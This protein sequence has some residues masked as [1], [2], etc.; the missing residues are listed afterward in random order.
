MA[1]GKLRD[2]RA[3]QVVEAAG[4]GRKAGAEATGKLT[5]QTGITPFKGGK[6]FVDK[7]TGETV[8]LTESGEVVPV[9]QLE[10]P[11]T[12]QEI[13]TGELGAR[14]RG[15]VEVGLVKGSERLA[16]LENVQ[17]RFKPEFLQVPTRLKAALLKGFEKVGGE[18]NEEDKQLVTEVTNFF[19]DARIN[20]NQTIQDITGAAMG[21]QEAKRIR[22]PEPDVG[23]GV[24]AGQSPTEFKANIDRSILNIRMAQAR[25]TKLLKE[26]FITNDE[27]A[28]RTAGDKSAS[29]LSID[30]MTSQ[31]DSRGEELFNQ[32]KRANPEMNENQAFR[33][34]QNRL[35]EE[36]GL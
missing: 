29:I 10:K 32:I 13:R 12:K 3:E 11:T 18:L 2:L 14:A 19:G 17:K 20:I 28:N 31:Y 9:G 34:A 25:Q 36:F 15:E 23:E 26:G 21:V 1:V 30:E 4:A 22:L 8:I 27:I 35:N 16:R 7:T 5:A 24:F 6:E 33:E